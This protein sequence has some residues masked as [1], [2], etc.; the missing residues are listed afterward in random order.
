MI[1][2]IEVCAWY[3]KFLF[4]YFEKIFKLKNIYL[5]T[6]KKSEKI[7]KNYDTLLI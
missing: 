7:N 4:P 6:M 3:C 5:L 2:F 1:I